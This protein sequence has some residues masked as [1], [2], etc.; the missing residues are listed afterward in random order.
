MVSCCFLAHFALQLFDGIHLTVTS[1]KNNSTFD[2]S[3][4]NTWLQSLMVSVAQFQFYK[5]SLPPVTRVFDMFSQFT[6]GEVSVT[7]LLFGEQN[8]FKK[9][10]V[11]P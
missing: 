7:A 9:A 4:T 1:Y 8:N 5:A 3:W 2:F 11:S 6:V 10:F